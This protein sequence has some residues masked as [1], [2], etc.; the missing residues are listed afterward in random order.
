MNR[1]FPGIGEVL[2]QGPVVEEQIFAQ[3]SIQKQLGKLC[4]GHRV[5]P[6]TVNLVR[7][8]QSALITFSEQVT[9][10]AAVDLNGPTIA[11]IVSK[12][13]AAIVNI[14]PYDNFT[15]R[16]GA[17]PTNSNVHANGG[18]NK[19]IEEYML[20]C[21]ILFQEPYQ[22]FPIIIAAEKN[23]TIIL[24]KAVDVMKARFAHFNFAQ[25]TTVVTYE[26]YFSH[27]PLGSQRSTVFVDGR[28]GGPRIWLNNN[29]IWDNGNL[30]VPSFVPN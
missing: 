22:P 9:C 6:Q 14:A 4:V 24:E 26:A 16:E 10:A 18:M 27:E 1:N 23:R 11:M 19:L 13:G 5:E 25:A 21:N 28:L 20:H 12:K 7:L 8:D 30:L 17:D 29:M 2:S 15:Q 3:Y